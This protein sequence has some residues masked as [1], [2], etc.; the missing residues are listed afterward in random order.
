MGGNI[1]ASLSHTVNLGFFYIISGAEEYF[2]K[3]V[4][5]KNRTLSA[6]A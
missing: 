6:H 3:D 1:S 4:A 5:R 2:S